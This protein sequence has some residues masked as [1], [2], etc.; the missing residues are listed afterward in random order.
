MEAMSLGSKAG[1][2]PLIIYDIISNAAGNSWVFKNQVPQFL[3][4]ITKQHYLNT[5][6]QKLGTVLDQAKSLTFPALLLSVA[7]QQL[8]LGSSHIGEGEDASLIKACERMMGVNISAAMNVESY[9]PEQ[10]AS[11]ITSSADS[12]NRIGFIGL[13]AMGFGMASH[14]L[15]SN[16]SV[17]GFD[18]YKPTQTRFSDIGGLIG[19][20]PAEVSK[21][22][23]EE[24]KSCIKA[25]EY[26]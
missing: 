24:V 19:N 15:K 25:C 8:I 6:I 3:Q 22:T 17:I 12:V 26:E 14:L 18:V 16:F 9:N 2:H 1:I 10:L 7:H 13:G 20:S 11:Q 23:L 5:S 4:G 21:G